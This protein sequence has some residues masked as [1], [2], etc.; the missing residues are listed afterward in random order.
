MPTNG[1]N[2]TKLAD[3]VTNFVENFKKD[4]A[5]ERRFLPIKVPKPSQIEI[6][7]ILKRLKEHYEVFHGICYTESALL[8]TAVLSY[9][10]ISDRFLPDKAVDLLKEAGARVSSCHA[11]LL[12]V[13]REFRT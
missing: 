13:A 2:L 8:A 11:Q 6:K 12:E 1:T 5:L 3:E 7:M 9:K 4:P 10:N